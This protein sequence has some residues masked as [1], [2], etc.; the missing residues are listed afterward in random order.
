MKSSCLYI[1]VAALFLSSCST[2]KSQKNP[3]APNE[4]LK[5]DGDQ[6]KKPQ[7]VGD[8]NNLQASDKISNAGYL[9]TYFT[10]NSK[11]DESIRFAVS[12]CGYT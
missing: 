10:G 4:Q 9:F 3:A 6:S 1:L 11:A 7:A 2:T 8:Q 12:R 5:A